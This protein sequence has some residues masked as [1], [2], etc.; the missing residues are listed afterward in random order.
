MI[1]A[2]VGAAGFFASTQ[3][4]AKFIEIQAASAA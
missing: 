4:L 2:A 3:S 1:R